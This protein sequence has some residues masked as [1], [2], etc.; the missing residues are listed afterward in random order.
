MGEDVAVGD[1]VADRGTVLTPG[2]LGVLANQGMAEV[3]VHPRPR[4]GVLSTGDE[5][6]STPGP[7]RPRTD[8]RRQPPSLLALVRRE[9]WVPVDLG[10]VG[11]DEAPL[12]DRA[13]RA[14]PPTATP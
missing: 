5:L 7:A 9:G 6:V 13:R 3:A 4:V 12:T 1:T 8:P 10:I 11:D 2:H 14:P